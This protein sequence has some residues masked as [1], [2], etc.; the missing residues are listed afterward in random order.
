MVQRNFTAPPDLSTAAGSTAEG[1]A[2][3]EASN[4]NGSLAAPL[5]GALKS[6]AT[7]AAAFFPVSEPQFCTLKDGAAVKC[8]MAFRSGD[9]TEAYVEGK[10]LYLAFESTMLTQ[11]SRR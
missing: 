3:L 10:P 8:S 2:L 4:G 6:E 5:L 9:L 11:A 1:Q 7:E